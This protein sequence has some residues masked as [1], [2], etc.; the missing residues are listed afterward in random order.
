MSDD[1]HREFLLS[2][3]RAASLRAK[4]FDA[5]VCTIGIALKACMISPVEAVMQLRDLG[6]DIG[7]IP[8]E[9]TN[10]GGE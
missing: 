6:A 3:L 4:L 2:A 1:T 8:D 9:I 5:D 10:G 7:K